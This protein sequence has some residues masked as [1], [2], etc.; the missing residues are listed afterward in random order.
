M[1]RNEMLRQIY[2]FGRVLSYCRGFVKAKQH[3]IF[4][5]VKVVFDEERVKNHKI[6]YDFTTAFML[7]AVPYPDIFLY[8]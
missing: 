5:F 4:M 6:S 3:K 8:R 1:Q 2:K 7:N